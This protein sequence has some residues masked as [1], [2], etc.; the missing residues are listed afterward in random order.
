MLS[1][2]VTVSGGILLCG[3]T[4]QAIKFLIKFLEVGNIYFLSAKWALV[5]SFDPL[6]NTSAVE[7][8]PDVTAQWS[9]LVC[10]FEFFEANRAF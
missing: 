10:F 7:I 5:L 8:M 1:S 6:L 4:Q 9:N 2:C 3:V